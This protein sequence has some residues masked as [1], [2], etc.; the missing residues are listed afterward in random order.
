MI[1]LLAHRYT[2]AI[3]CFLLTLFYSSV[4]MPLYGSM[5]VLAA[6]QPAAVVRHYNTYGKQAVDAFAQSYKQPRQAVSASY[7]VNNNRHVL[8]KAAFIDGPNQPEMTSFKSVSA[9]NMVNLFTGDF[10]YS[11][12]L[13]DVGGY[14]IN[15][16]Y[17]GGVGVEQQASWVGLG[18]NINPGNVN[19]NMRG[20]PDDFNGDDTMIHQQNMK[21]NITWGVNVGGDVE[22]AG[23]KKVP[24]LN[25]SLGAAVGVSFNNY[26]G[27]AMDLDLKAGAS[28]NILSKVLSEKSAGDSLKL[29]LD[30][31]LNADINSRYGFTLSPAVSLTASAFA[32]ERKANLGLTAST[33]YN[34]RTGIKQ[35]QIAEQWSVSRTEN[36][37]KMEAKKQAP[38]ALAVRMYG[39]LAYYDMKTIHHSSSL[40]AALWSN[41]ITFAR[42]SY[43]PSIRMPVTNNSYT[44]RFQL[45][46]ALW[47]VYPSA[48]IEVYKQTASISEQDR[49]QLKPMVGYLY[50]QKAVDNASAVMDFTRFND[51]EVTPTTP[52]VSVPQYTYDI[53]TING[54]GTGGSIRA[55]RND[56]GYVKDNTTTSRESS[57]GA[58]V[59]IGIPGHYGA[60]FNTVTTPST[61]GDWDNNNKLRTSLRFG[62]DHENAEAVY[63]RNPGEKSVINNGQYYNIG[64]AD[65]VR[66]K[67]GGSGNSP[68][69]EPVLER[70]SKTLSPLG[71]RSMITSDNSGR[72]KRTQ[73]ISYLTAAEARKIGLDTNIV[74]YRLQKLDTLYRPLFSSN[75]RLEYYTISRTSAY[76]KRHHISQ[77][78]VTES[79]GQRYIYGIPVYNIV[80]KDFTFSVNPTDPE[81]DLVAADS[82]DMETSSAK[83]ASGS[84][85]DG[86]V[87]SVQTPAYAHSF[88]LTGLLSQDYVD[89]TGDG[90]SE[91]DLGTAVK[92]NYT[93]I[94]NSVDNDWAVH[95]WRTPLTAGKMA[96]FNAGNR[97]ES[98]DD[99][100]IVSYGER[101][102]WYVHS[103]ES[104]TMIALFTLGDRKD[105]KGPKSAY[106][107]IDTN[108]VSAKCLKRIDL[109]NKADLQS[110]GLA[111]AKPVKS[112]FF[113][114]SYKLCP[115]TPDNATAGNGKL[116]LDSV[117]FTFNGQSRNFKNRYV[118]SYANG[119]QD[120]PSW[121]YNGSD[122]WGTYKPSV[123][124]PEGMKNSDYPYSLQDSAAKNTIDNNAG[125]WMLK[126][127]L[128]P[129]GGQ[130][131]VDYE[132]DDYAFVQNKRA[133]DMMQVAGFGADSVH[134][135]TGLY[136]ASGLSGIVDH[137]YLFIKV[138]QR[139]ASRTD[140]FNKYLD[141]VSQLAVKLMVSM[142]KYP[143]YLTSYATVADYGTLGSGDTIWVRMNSVAGLSPLSLTAVEYLREQLPGQAFP[144]Y[145]VSESGGIK[146]VGEMLAG[147]L[148]AITTAF[149]NPVNVLRSKGYAMAVNVQKSFVRLN[150]PDGFKYGGG[151]RVKAV[152]LKDNWTA[153]TGQ[154]NSVYG[155]KYDYTTTE[156][157]YGVTRTISSGVAS[158]EPSM[159]GEENP[160]QTSVQISSKLPLGPASYGAIEMPVLDAFFPSPLVGY[161]KV[162]VKAINN[163]LGNDTLHKSRSGI[164]KQVTEFYT[165]KD[166]PVYYTNTSLD[167]A[168]DK[169]QHSSSTL[170]FF[171]K[172]SID[173]R[174]VSQGFLVATNDMHGQTKS[175]SSYAETD[176]NSRIAYQEYFYKN[177]GGNG[178]EEKFDF[179]SAAQGGV[180]TQGNMGVDVELMTDAREFMAK[181]NSF[182]IQ[183]QV[184]LFPVLFPFWIPFIWPVFGSSENTYRAVTT[185]KVI[186]YHS[187]LDSMVMVDKGSMV[188]T[189]NMLYDAETGMLVVSKTNNQFNQAVY[190][191]SYPA[192]W[193]YGGMGLA[194]KNINAVYTGINF[195]DGKITNAS[196]NDS[197]LESGDEVYILNAGAAAD[198]CA[199]TSSDTLT[200]L[201]VFNKNKN[202]TSLASANDY[203]FLD[204]KGNT[205]SRTG[206]SFRIVR[207]GKRNMLSATIGQI[208]SMSNPVMKGADSIAR[209]QP[210]AG[211]K[212][213]NASAV[214]YKEKWQTDNDVIKKYV[215]VTDNLACVIKEVV[216]CNG[217]LEKS[218][219]PYVKGLMGNFTSWRSLV[220]YGS[221]AESDPASVTNISKNGYLDNF[222]Y[223]W[224][225]N[226]TK[227]LFPD[228]ANSK[229]VWNSQITRVNSKGQ[230]VENKNALNIYTS[231]QYGYN[232]SLPVAIA[233]NARSYEMAYTG[234][235][236]ATYKESLGSDNSYSCEIKHVDFA[237]IGRLV[238]T[239]TTS[240]TAHTGKYVMAVPAYSNGMKEFVITTEPADS[241]SLKFTTD[242]GRTL[243]DPGTFLNFFNRSD[244]SIEYTVGN[245]SDVY[246]NNSFVQR[247]FK[248]NEWVREYQYNYSTTQYFKVDTKGTHM[249]SVYRN[250]TM[251]G[252]SINAWL[253]DEKDN[254][255]SLTKINGDQSQ[256]LTWSDYT[257]CLDKGIYKLISSGSGYY[258]FSC[259][260]IN[261]PEC[262]DQQYDAVDFNYASFDNNTVVGYKSNNTRN[263]C[264]TTVPI[265]S[266]ASMLNP[267][268]NVVMGKKMLFSAW[269]KRSSATPGRVLLVYD[270]YEIDTLDAA[271]P[272]IDGWQRIEGDFTAPA[273]TTKMS[274]L[275]MNQAENDVLYVDDVRMH[276]YN[277]NMKS[278]V[279]DPVNLRMV[280]ELDANNY[281]T[282]Y[283]YD[284]EGGLIR[285][286][287]ET[288][289]GIKTISE[290]RSAKQKNITTIQ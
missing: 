72:K 107:Y 220:F 46:G 148:N 77:V 261:G 263:G 93:R 47:G 155:Q 76:R 145:D 48:S 163:I 290:T 106:G 37:L 74:S 86:Y 216:D 195:N 143:E 212:V 259:G 82:T 1:Q 164:G 173:R 24:G 241:V 18:W 95:K 80:Q 44:G 96:N 179:V 26:L 243:T 16:Y 206:V 230:E 49:K 289:E 58:G 23:I 219:N 229:W 42:P 63:F 113:A 69:I 252:M 227:N 197:I 166:Y 89:V 36:K 11:I 144:G 99:K 136:S 278:Y 14:P 112:V 196:F 140:A 255:V 19:R 250:N 109:Y 104:K 8:G 15:I 38:T 56:L 111:K 92:F 211:G 87:Q 235:E 249:V 62:A 177:T 169:Q 190:N 110:N 2:K 61:S 205:Y 207:S 199:S 55:Y 139:V 84:G 27:P 223:Y 68:S 43:T 277:A 100:G 258:Y 260:V 142:P 273:G 183:G 128:L 245:F 141:G 13:M 137:Q 234:F 187:V 135:K 156:T 57:D 272:V 280:A 121:S 3:A 21:P 175:Q 174:A 117:Y 97:S 94:R 186:T 91:D 204:Y 251:E 151:Y 32:N 202:L 102:S 189:K 131:E 210:D 88:L 165:A 120:N 256:Y 213:I 17:D 203:I 114:Y 238:N 28:Y 31:S 159:G 194:Y 262:E 161:S 172:T 284:E 79:N 150:D 98:K 168:S 217:Y 215:K 254:L 269:V 54:E 191:T 225:F 281:A 185:T 67:L 201:W 66:V 231:A 41:S 239:D 193:A 59:D 10:S 286:K 279:Y 122:R 226:T 126:K 85:V 129:S 7:A 65:L 20:V 178:L 53:F 146:Q 158:Y 40:G 149:S 4:I 154:Y 268:Y 105:A 60:N 81:A 132:S 233:N 75:N 274:V 52:V 257:C 153:M 50:Y 266:T 90:I 237:T 119:A 285:V 244:S 83:T 188:S 253:Y 64:D 127:I 6:A 221:R 30:V 103:I 288:V 73:V 170:S 222:T 45:G 267:V 224:K 167:P 115:G 182:E 152:R 200:R 108:D 171:N 71:D 208:I 101:E 275:F 147:M 130:I 22:F 70:F 5:K 162:T 228:T 34:S 209:L 282:Y 181:G 51:K 240:I 9:D 276:P 39:A 134:C 116:T 133:M 29:G 184:D 198:V 247:Q 160:F 265:A 283:E 157:A 35:M 246:I 180:V 123:Q 232:K 33:S 214:E 125:A 12:P 287:A 236:D 270:N 218:I 264:V 242:T 176:S 192:Y 78:N 248:G 271:G 138:P 25:V 118:F 124:N